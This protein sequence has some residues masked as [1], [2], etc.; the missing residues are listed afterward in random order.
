MI[1]RYDLRWLVV[2][3]CNLLL[4]WLSALANQRLAQF[5][6]LSWDYVSIHL[7]LGGLFVVFSGLYMDFR[8][9]FISTALTGLAYDALEPVPFGTSLVL[10]GLI[11]AFLIF[12]RYRFSIQE[13]IFAI[14]VAFLSNLLLVIAI[15]SLLIGNGSEPALMW[16]R[17]LIDLIIS[18]IVLAP[19]TP[20]FITFQIVVLKIF[21]FHGENHK[22]VNSV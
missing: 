5:S 16:L 22:N 9:G 15:S 10:F 20:W 12:N 14:I 1:Y 21:R 17:L 3:G 18:Q 6:F 8:N 2:F 4:L 13:P 7:Y 19:I 11:H